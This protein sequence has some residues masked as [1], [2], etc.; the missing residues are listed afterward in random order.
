M[1]DKKIRCTATIVGLLVCVTAGAASGDDWRR[2][3]TEGKLDADLGN[4]DEASASFRAIADDESAPNSLRWEA[5]V[6][7]GLTRN[8]AG[9]PAAST[10][11][12]RTV[13]ASY[14][15]DPK[16]MRF[17][18]YAVA[19]SGPGKIWIDLKVKF[20]ELL[21]TARVVSTEELGP[22][23][24]A[25]KLTLG[26]GEIEL[27]AIWKPFSDTRLLREGQVSRRSE[28]AAYE[29]DKM[30]GLDMVPPT[31]LRTLEGQEGA[32][33]LWVY[34]C[35]TYGAVREDAPGTPEW[36]HHFSRMEA[37]D[38][39]IGNDA[40]NDRNIL[41]DATWGVVLIDHSL[42]FSE[43]EA[44]IELPSRFDRRMLER[45][46]RLNRPILRKHLN[47]V[48]TEAQVEGVLERRDALLAHVQ[49][50]VDEQGEQAVLF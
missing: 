38:H 8:A 19:S 21:R 26:K 20:E 22:G 48:L 18:T 27:S 36:R 42:G 16:A 41:V 10:Q 39:V 4:H 47:D 29:I 6:R 35:K 12:F 15:G 25:R 7:Y 11:A 17:V 31:V 30:L 9:D 32:L 50:L 40:R 14:A 34:G 46:R 45:L 44:D 43:G 28:I 2:L 24:Q 5:L 33:Q 23:I 1:M 13:L 3:M 37:F 49:Q